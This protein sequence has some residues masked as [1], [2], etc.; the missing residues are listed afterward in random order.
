MRHEGF[1]LY[2]PFTREIHESVLVGASGIK[3]ESLQMVTSHEL[4]A[5]NQQSSGVK[6]TDFA[7]QFKLRGGVL[8]P[9]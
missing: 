2:V 4:E 9:K 5:V 3:S 1:T 6:L 8:E 7:Y